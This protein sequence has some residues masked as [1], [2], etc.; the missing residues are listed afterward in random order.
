M[1]RENN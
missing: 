1:S